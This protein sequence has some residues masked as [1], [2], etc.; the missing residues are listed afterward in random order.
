MADQST[1]V[2]SLPSGFATLAGL[3]YAVS[4]T[5]PEFWSNTA[6]SKMGG[7]WSSRIHPHFHPDPSQT[8]RLSKPSRPYEQGDSTED[9]HSR[10][11][12]LLSRHV[13][14]R[15]RK[16]RLHERKQRRWRPW[17]DTS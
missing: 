11:C 13:T 12:F 4:A 1:T 16:I 14:A 17:S 3:I 15:L 2:A 7:N 8:R 9:L 6:W 10:L 5:T